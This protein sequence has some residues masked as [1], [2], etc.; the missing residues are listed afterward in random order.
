MLAGGELLCQRNQSGQ[1]FIWET[2]VVKWF[3]NSSLQNGGLRGKV[4]QGFPFLNN[5]YF[6]TF[7]F[8]TV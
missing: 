7:P 5:I 1:I 3:L 4:V 2:Q 8:S 6:F